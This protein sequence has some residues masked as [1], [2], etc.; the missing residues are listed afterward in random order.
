MNA[1]PW[2]NLIITVRKDGFKDAKRALRHYGT[3]SATQFFNVLVA[4]VDNLSDFLHDFSQEFFR[5]SFLQDRISRI[6]PLLNTFTFDSKKDF[7]NKIK[8]IITPW[9]PRLK[10][11]SFHVRIH[12][13]G[14]QELSTLEEEQFLDRFIMETLHS[15]N[16]SAHVSFK[17]PDFIIDV[18]TI[19]KEAGVSIWS[20]AEL[21][22]HPFINLD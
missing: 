19:N 9:I 11:N 3:I 4:H 2:W 21:R 13:R 1:Q 18:E 15:Q 8:E 5:H 16:A 12:S 20:A 10:E 17:N 22:E 7:E 6:T 14:V